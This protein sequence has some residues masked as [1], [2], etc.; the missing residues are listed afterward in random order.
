M[1]TVVETPGYLADAKAAGLSD[2]VRQ[3]I[4]LAVSADPK[5]GELLVGT[6]GLRKFRFS[7]R[8]G[9]KRGG[10]RVLSFYVSEDF[11]C[12]SS[13][14][15]QE[16]EGQHHPRGTGRTGQASQG[17][18]RKIQNQRRR[19]MTK[20]FDMIMRGLGE[21]EEYL[22]GEREGYAVHI[23]D[24]VDV[25]AIRQKLHLSQPKFAA[26]F[27]FS[28]GRL[29]DWEQKRF[30]IDAPSRVLLTVIDREPDAV[31]RA[32]TTEVRKPGPARSRQRPG[33]RPA[34]AKTV[35]RA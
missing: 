1:H 27:G 34:R 18:G 33:D 2:E 21:V 9:G 16:P 7:R 15:R 13:G 20:T 32:L 11:R 24:E 23:P 31:M 22:D 30:P 35:V 3:A 6:S 25:K 8:G 19:A 5:I 29:R 12:F 28:V 10:F 4:V 14:V 26:T 17:D